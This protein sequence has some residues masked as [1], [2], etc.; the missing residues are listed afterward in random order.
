MVAELRISTIPLI[1]APSS[2]LPAQQYSFGCFPAITTRLVARESGDI[3]CF[4]ANRT[5]DAGKVEVYVRSS[6]TLVHRS[7]KPRL[8]YQ[9]SLEQ[10]VAFSDGSSRFLLGTQQLTV[11]NSKRRCVEWLFLGH[12][13]GEPFHAFFAEKVL[14]V[15][16]SGDVSIHL[17]CVSQKVLHLLISLPLAVL[18]ALARWLPALPG[19]PEVSPWADG[20]DNVAHICP[21]RAPGDYTDS[22]PD[23]CVVAE[24]SDWVAVAPC[25]PDCVEIWS[26]EKL[27][28]YD[29][30]GVCLCCWEWRFLLGSRVMLG[31]PLL[32]AS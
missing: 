17:R 13:R 7:A 15:I 30:S 23:Q 22:S 6:P 24:D 1:S 3:G 9:S 8:A 31:I 32:G 27:V 29:V 12:V 18:L 21:G 26:A 5:R 16:S 25:M 14:T 28:R 4:F 11:S 20:S 10:H 19:T 2:P